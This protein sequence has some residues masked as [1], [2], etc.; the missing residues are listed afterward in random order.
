MQI[1]Q[2]PKA[3][4]FYQILMVGEVREVKVVEYKVT[5]EEFDEDRE[6]D[7]RESER[8]KSSSKPEKPH[9]SLTPEKGPCQGRKAASMTVITILG[10]GK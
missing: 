10:D 9:S 3:P 6:R 2:L 7:E 5:L 8:I 4:T 1:K